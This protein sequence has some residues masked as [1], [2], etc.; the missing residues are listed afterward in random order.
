MLDLCI[1][2]NVLLDGLDPM[3][4]NVVL[5]DRWPYCWRSCWRDFV[6]RISSRVAHL[7]SRISCRVSG[8]PS[9]GVASAD[10]LYRSISRADVP[11]SDHD[12]DGRS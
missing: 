2:F 6:S 11:L 7:V 12:R 3:P 5:D 9:A 1:P 8:S 4:F 10:S